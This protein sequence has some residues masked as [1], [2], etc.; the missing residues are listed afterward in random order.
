MP[1]A[2]SRQPSLSFSYWTMHIAPILF[3]LYKS[4]HRAFQ[5]TM[6]INKH[7]LQHKNILWQV[8]IITSGWLIS[9]CK[10][11]SK[12][13]LPV[14]KYHASQ[15]KISHSFCQ[16]IAIVLRFCLALFGKGAN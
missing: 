7:V 10:T 5:L 2:I 16:S 14:T 4:V 6:I 15:L 11:E 9:P 13:Q 8:V 12:G 3:I 1:W